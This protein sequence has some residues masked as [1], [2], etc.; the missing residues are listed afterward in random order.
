TVRINPGRMQTLGVRTA[1]AEMRPAAERSVRAAGT[2]QVEEPR[3]AAVTATGP[4]QLDDRPPAPVTTK[5]SG[6]VERLAVAATGDP[7]RRGQVMAEIYSPELVASENEY[8]IAAQMGGA[9]GTAALQRL[10]ALDIPAEELARLRRTG[11]S[12]LC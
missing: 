8:L 7:V 3:R 2:V 11:R 10:Q 9:I 5:V 6:W 1:A 12:A 4:F